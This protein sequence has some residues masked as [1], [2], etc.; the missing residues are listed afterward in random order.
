MKALD[1]LLDVF[2]ELVSIT[3][4]VPLD[5]VILADQGRSAP[6]GLEVYATYNP[7]PIRAYGQVRRTRELSAPAEQSDPALG[8]DWQD[9]QETACSSLEITLSTNFFNEGAVH[10]AMMLQNANFRSPVSEFLFSHQ[11]AWRYTGN[12]QN[13]TSL[14]QAGLQPRFHADIH[15]FIDHEVSYPVLRA[16]GFRIETTQE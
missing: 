5:R 10:A 4:G 6:A 13:L 11:I 15:L 1:E 14:M 8:S 16:A 12:L 2:R 3:T 7:I 9:M